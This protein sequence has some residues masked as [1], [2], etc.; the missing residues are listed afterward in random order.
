MYILAQI[1]MDFKKFCTELDKDGSP[2]SDGKKAQN[3][4]D[5]MYSKGLR[6]IVDRAICIEIGR[7]KLQVPQ[8]KG[9]LES[10]RFRAIVVEQRAIR[11]EP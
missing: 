4:E 6:R 7:F 1:E 10:D 3:T 5:P 9:F 2:V 11:V 8:F